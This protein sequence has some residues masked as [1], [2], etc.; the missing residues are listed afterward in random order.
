[1]RQALDSSFVTG[2]DPLDDYRHALDQLAGLERAVAAQQSQG[3][4]LDAIMQLRLA[5]VRA[6]GGRRA[7]NPA[8][9]GAPTL[10]LDY[11]RDH[12]GEWV[13]GEELAA[14]SGIGEWA[15]RIRELRVERGYDIEE[16]GGRYRLL[17]SEPDLERK[18]RWQAVSEIKDFRGDPLDRVRTLL[19]RLVTR[20]VTVDELD[21]V[22]RNRNGARLARELRESERMPVESSVDAPDLS[23]GEFRLVSNHPWHRIGEDQHHFS[24]D[25]RAAVFERDRYRCWTCGL[26][27]G[28]A[29]PTAAEP[30]YLVVKHLDAAGERLDRLPIGSLA[31]LSRMATVCNR[32]SPGGTQ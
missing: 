1:V 3:E 11:L 25:L 6:Y 16:E 12:L 10:L 4:V 32:C 20:V 31:E 19:E 23:P 13:Y 9:R 24:E 28:A 26:D 27:R 15:R 8:G 18:E 5:V 21:R 7:R 30:F 2:S 17:S 29:A 22:A 14:V